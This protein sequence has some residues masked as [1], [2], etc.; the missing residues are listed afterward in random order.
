MKVYTGLY[1]IKAKRALDK[2][3]VYLMGSIWMGV[4]RSSYGEYVLTCPTNIFNE[5]GQEKFF[6]EMLRC[7]KIEDQSFDKDCEFVLDKLS[8]MRP[9][10][11]IEKYRKK[12]IDEFI[13]TPFDEFK[14]AQI[15]YLESEAKKI[16]ENA[17][18]YPLSEEYDKLKK[19]IKS[20]KM[21]NV[22]KTI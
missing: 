18:F 13:G 12:F 5:Y 9:N 11:L 22:D 10:E 7:M 6:K 16:F 1:S 3:S 21:M 19:K 14:A 8:N 17:D 2:I 15:D 4:D 20:L